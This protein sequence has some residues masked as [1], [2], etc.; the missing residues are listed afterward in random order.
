MGRRSPVRMS[1]T[2]GSR[3]APASYENTSRL[4]DTS[5]LVPRC[6]TEIDRIPVSG[7]ASAAPAAP[8]LAATAVAPTT[9]AGL[10]A[11]VAATAFVV[12]VAG[13]VEASD[14]TGFPGTVAGTA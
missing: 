1:E 8:G 11:G 4:S 2:N 3:R 12:A 5:P 13:F 14:I 9:A 10:A 7:P 6:V